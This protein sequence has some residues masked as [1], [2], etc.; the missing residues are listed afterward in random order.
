MKI[1]NTIESPKKF[2]VEELLEFLAK[3]LK[4]NEDV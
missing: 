4:I 3:E 2:D 1:E